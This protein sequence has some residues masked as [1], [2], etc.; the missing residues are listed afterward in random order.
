VEAVVVEVLD[1]GLAQGAAALVDALQPEL[2]EQVLLQ[3]QAWLWP[4][5]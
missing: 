3:G 4:L 1:Q 5:L 2:P